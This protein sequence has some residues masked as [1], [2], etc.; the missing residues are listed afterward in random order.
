[1]TASK[2]KSM[3][4]PNTAIKSGSILAFSNIVLQIVKL[5]IEPKI[6]VVLNPDIKPH[7]IF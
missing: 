5:M 7:S 1:M 3:S 6:E 4:S 2:P